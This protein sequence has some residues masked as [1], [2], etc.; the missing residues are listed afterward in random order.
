VKVNVPSSN[1]L[2]QPSTTAYLLRFV[3]WMKRVWT[4]EGS[5]PDFLYAALDTTA[6]AAFIKESR[7]KFVNATH[8]HRKSGLR[9]HVQ[10]ARARRPGAREEYPSQ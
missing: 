6:C 2:I 4:P 8:F 5:F 9:P 1:F 7:M 10:G 3:Y